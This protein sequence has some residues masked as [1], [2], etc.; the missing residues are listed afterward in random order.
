MQQLLNTRQ[1]AA[2]ATQVSGVRVTPDALLRLASRGRGPSFRR[3][4]DNGRRM[5]DANSV[6]EWARSRLGPEIQTRDASAFPLS[7]P[8]GV[9]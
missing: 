8:A 9:H 4:L 1:A 6:R 7:P 3:L 2:L 5:F